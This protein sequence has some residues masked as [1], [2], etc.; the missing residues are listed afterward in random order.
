MSKTVYK[1]KEPFEWASETINELEF[2]K[3]TIGDIKFMKLEA[4]T[5]DDILKLASKLSGH[6]QQVIDRLSIQDGMGV[7][8]IL[9][10]YLNPSQKIGSQASEQ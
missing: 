7:A 3:P 9:G 5:L 4:M 1:L 10:N 6:S 8:E 2:K